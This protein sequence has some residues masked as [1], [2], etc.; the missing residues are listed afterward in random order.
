MDKQHADI[1]VASLLAMAQTLSYDAS[2]DFDYK[3]TAEARMA[4]AIRA[5]TEHEV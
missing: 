4:E 3:A 1:R 5:T 2:E